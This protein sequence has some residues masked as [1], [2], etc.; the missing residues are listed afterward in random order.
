[1]LDSFHVAQNRVQK[2]AAVKKWLSS[3]NISR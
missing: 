2:R 1:V 3:S